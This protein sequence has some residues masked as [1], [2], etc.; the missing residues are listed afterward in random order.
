MDRSASSLAT[1]FDRHAGWLA[2]ACCVLSLIGFA[3]ALPAFSHVQHP[4]GLLGASGVPNAAVFNVLAF[5]VPGLLATWVFVRLRE[6][7][8][9]DAGRMGGLG[10]WLLAISAL[11]FA[12]QGVFP[13]DPMDLDGPVS[14]RHATSW[15]LW[16]LAFVP[17]ALL[18]ALGLR[19]QPGRARAA[20]AFLVAGVLVVA[21]NL[22]PTA[23][24]PGPVAQRVIV[25]VWLGCVVLASRLR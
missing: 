10:P 7:L 16:W 11:A 20:M 19:G 18:L 8:P 12:A 4:P 21:L 6:R 15:L 5:V 2:A 1:A 3:A 9:R 23:W 25:L 14:Q 17:G 22:L 13:L 24:I